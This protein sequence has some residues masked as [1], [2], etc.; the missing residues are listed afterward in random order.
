MLRFSPQLTIRRIRPFRRCG[1]GSLNYIA[2]SIAASSIPTTLFLGA[3]ASIP[4]GAPSGP[5]LADDLT[6][7]FFEGER[8]RQL[9]DISGRVELKYGRPELVKFLR[10]KLEPLEPSNTLLQ[11]PSFNFS[12]IFTTNY[13][14]L[15][16]KAFERSGVDLPIVRS[17]KDYA[18]DHRQYNTVLFKLH[19]CI[20]EDRADGLNHGMIITDEDYAT[21]LH[22]REIGFRHFEQSLS[23]SNVVFVGFS[24]ADA[25]IKE[26]VERAISLAASSECPGQAFLI[27]YEE[28]EIEGAR[29]RNRGLRVGFGDLDAFLS[30]LA[31]VDQDP[32]TVSVFSPVSEA[33]R[34]VIAAQISSVDPVVEGEKSSNIKRMVS[35]S[36]V[37]YADIRAGNAFSRSVTT[38]IVQQTISAIDT[39]SLHI[40][41]GPSGAG[42]TSAGRLAI[43]ELSKRGIVCY[44]H[45]SHIP[46]DFPTWQDVEKEHRS[47]GEQSCLFLDEPNASQYAVNQLSR[48]LVSDEQRALSVIIAYHPSIWSYRTKSSELIKKSKQHDMSRLTPADIQNIAVHVRRKSEIARLLSTDIQS[49]TNDQIAEIIRRRARSDLFVSLKYIFETRS[50]DEI[51][52]RE[53]EQIGQEKPDEIQTSVRSLY[54]T[55]ALLEACGRHVHRQMVFRVTNVE[56]VEISKL[57]DYLE[58]VI[59][60]SER[61][62]FVG[63]TYQWTTRHPRIASIIAESK[64]SRKTRRDLL[65]RVIKSINP[66]SK[67][68]RQ[69]SA[70]LCNSEIGI[71]SL[72]RGDQTDLYKLLVNVVPGERVPRHRLIRN[73]IQQSDFG[74][75]EIA[76]S[77]AREMNINDSVIYRYDVMLNVA[78]AEK[79]EFL[80]KPDRLNLLDTAISKATRSLSRRPDDMFNFESY[81]RASLAFAQNGG[82]IEEFEAAL[83][84][85]KDA[86]KDLGDPLMVQWIGKYESELARLRAKDH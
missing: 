53:F 17:N 47:K 26:Y 52:L 65:E 70:Q 84:K 4:S 3:G 35:G 56:A 51:V 60:E 33:P 80:E 1:L 75:A 8:P 28:D 69:F 7:R 40:L 14:L 49:M 62:D 18:F 85:L 55:V 77:E 24:M 48:Y 43:H 83:Q 86:H 74:D 68:E 22:F 71:E 82:G 15:V 81:C 76:I 54:E 21:Y 34:H 64:F 45:K 50:L 67:I 29:W 78:K 19:G 57:L 20:T 25:S 73:L 5:S 59:F 9:S 37:T 13:D 39:S 6:I 42:K 66:A 11:L 12:N 61:D 46:V 10:S 23:T 63:G 41:I 2:K 27:L 38:E 36:P 44:E 79:L 32:N 58:G 31:S 30:A 72:P 16:E